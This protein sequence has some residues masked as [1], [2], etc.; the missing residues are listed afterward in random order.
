[1]MSEGI[2]NGSVELPLLEDRELSR[3]AGF[4][5]RKII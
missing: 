5:F 4:A 1:M 3:N 2:L